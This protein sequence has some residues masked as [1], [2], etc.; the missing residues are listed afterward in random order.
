M[1]TENR[2][3]DQ[4][5]VSFVLGR[6]VA[7]LRRR[8]GVSAEALAGAMNKRRPYVT[9]IE[10]G[11]LT[12]A[13]HHLFE[14]DRCLVKTGAL[15]GPGLLY[16]R[17]L[18]LRTLLERA[19]VTVSD[20]QPSLADVQAQAANWKARIAA[21]EANASSV[22]SIDQFDCSPDTQN[23]ARRLATG[24]LVRALRNLSGLSQAALSEDLSFAQSVLSTIESGSYS[25]TLEKLVELESLYIRQGVLDRPG[26]LLR[27]V[28]QLPRLLAAQG[29]PQDKQT[30][31]D[32]TDHLASAAAGPS[33]A[34]C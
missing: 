12:P 23:E 6:L 25:P 10:G 13:L 24:S 8:A 20:E 5:P 9:K 2:D 34:I 18:G 17:L 21:V 27:L 31:R 33:A 11:H 30:L 19:G 29:W 15:P 22:N 3:A 28:G 14:L 16:F 32:L 26:D 4:I 1:S 7:G